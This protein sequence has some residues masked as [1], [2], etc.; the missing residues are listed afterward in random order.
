MRIFRGEN[1]FRNGLPICVNRVEESFDTSMHFHDFWEMTYIAE[2]QGTHHSGDEIMPVS[3][4]NLFMVPLGVS[5]VFR[6]MSLNSKEPLIVYNFLVDVKEL[7]KFIH[8]FPGGN[9]L[10]SLLNC[11]E[12]KRYH[13]N[14]GKYYDLFQQMHYEFSADLPGKEARLYNGLMEL[15]LFFYSSESRT[16]NE[17]TQTAAYIQKVLAIMHADYHQ[18]LR[19][20]DLALVAGIGERQFQRIFYMQTN[21]TFKQYLQ[22][23]R[24][25][26]A[27]RLLMQTDR[28][29]TD[30]ANSVGY[31]DIPYFNK[32]FKEKT[33]MSPR[34]YRNSIR[35]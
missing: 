35:E 18:P 14:S 12:F 2:G 28:K 32:L 31:H 24:M 19:V 33:G 30:I 8:S 15:L 7:K 20:K 27:C 9:E 29:V 11:K 3:K 1:Y 26:H 21:M 25:N 13:D 10:E 5:H 22:G 4:G 16:Y 23:I 17:S 6:P 34:E